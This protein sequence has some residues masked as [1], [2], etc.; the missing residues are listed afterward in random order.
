MAPA[1][2]MVTETCLSPAV[3][4]DPIVILNVVD[5]PPTSEQLAVKPLT[6]VL[7]EAAVSCVVVMKLAPVTVMVL[8]A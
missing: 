3:V 6:V 7:H 8:P 4:T 1:V 2:K 5:G